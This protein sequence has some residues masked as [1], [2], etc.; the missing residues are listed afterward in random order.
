MWGLFCA[1]N[2]GLVVIV[3]AGSE[4]TQVH[5]PWRAPHVRPTLNRIRTSGERESERS[6]VAKSQNAMHISPCDIN[7]FLP[8]RH[9]LPQGWLQI[10][11]EEEKKYSTMLVC[12]QGLTNCNMVNILDMKETSES[13]TDPGTAPCP[14]TQRWSF[15]K[16]K[17]RSAVEWIKRTFC[18]CLP[19]CWWDS[20]A[21]RHC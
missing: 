16:R 3:G 19:H 14:L 13:N 10:K 2:L 1:R 17:K 8:A 4:T 18:T 9:N 15:R 5:M 20:L 12:V 21:K 11:T 7:Q 6:T